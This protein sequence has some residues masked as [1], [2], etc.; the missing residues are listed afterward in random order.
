M[1]PPLALQLWISQR[2]QTRLT[3]T[4]GTLDFRFL[5]AYIVTNA[6]KQEE[7]S[8]Y[9]T[10]RQQEILAYLKRH[11]TAFG[12][13]PSF[14]EISRHFHLSSLATVHKHL[15]N[16]EKKGMIRR[17]W[18][19]SRSVEIV[20]EGAEGCEVPLLGRIAAGRPIEAIED[21]GAISIPS[22]MLGR[23]RTYILQ[24]SGDSMIDDGI[25]DGDYVIVEERREARNGEMVVALLDGEDVTLKKYYREGQKIRLEPANPLMQPIR[26]DE[27]KVTIQGIVIGLLRKYRGA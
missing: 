6:E 5:F 16:L 21:V 18:N 7:T 19:R 23:N 17:E 26:V 13:A 3:Q 24:V 22:D 27:E 10:K 25:R 8:M 4:R 14:E 11:I 2:D 1:V 20:E 9:L 15:S 12:Y